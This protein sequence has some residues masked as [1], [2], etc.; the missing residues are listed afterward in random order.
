M[1]LDRDP[2]GAFLVHRVTKIREPKRCD[3]AVRINIANN[4][5]G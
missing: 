3:C 2:C 5:L 1:D 4:A